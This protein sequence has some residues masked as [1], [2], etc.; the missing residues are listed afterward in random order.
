MIEIKQGDTA[1]V[2][3]QRLR[4]SGQTIDFSN[5]DNVRFRMVDEYENVVIDDGLSGNVTIIDAPNGKVEYAWDSDDTT[6]IGE[7]EA[8]WIIEFSDGRR[9]SVPNSDYIDVVISE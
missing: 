3:E 8:E 4:L 2:L 7:F 5:V 9:L 6:D 1:P